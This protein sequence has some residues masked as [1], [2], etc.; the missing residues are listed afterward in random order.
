MHG[1]IAI[2]LLEAKPNNVILIEDRIIFQLLPLSDSLDEGNNKSAM[3]GTDYA[4]SVHDTFPA[5]IMFYS[6][7]IH[8]L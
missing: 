6:M 4:A 2:K 8:A 3:L 1:S 5:K 7:A